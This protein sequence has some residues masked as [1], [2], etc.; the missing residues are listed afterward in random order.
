MEDVFPTLF[1]EFVENSRKAMKEAGRGDGAKGRELKPMV[2]PTEEVAALAPE[3]HLYF[4]SFS[5]FPGCPSSGKAFVICFSADLT[6]IAGKID[7]SEPGEKRKWDCRGDSPE[8]L[9]RRAAHQCE[10]S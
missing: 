4:L 5:V 9:G 10:N 3:F 8:L 2:G 1:Q 6:V 7:P